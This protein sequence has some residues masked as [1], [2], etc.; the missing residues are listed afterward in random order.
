MKVSHLVI[1][2]NRK[3]TYMW[4]SKGTRKTI[5]LL[6]YMIKHNRKMISNGIKQIGTSLPKKQNSQVN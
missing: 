4:R 5:A 2:K 6:K 3:S 1:Y